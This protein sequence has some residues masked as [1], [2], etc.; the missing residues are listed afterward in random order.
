MHVWVFLVHVRV[1]FTTHSRVG[2]IFLWKVVPLYMKT[3]LSRSGC[4]VVPHLKHKKLQNPFDS[5]DFGPDF[6]VGPYLEVNHD[7]NELTH[8]KPRLVSEPRFS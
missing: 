7:V 3:K 2:I 5:N 4:N 6:K 8:S 1:L